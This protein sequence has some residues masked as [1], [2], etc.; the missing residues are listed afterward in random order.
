MT[1]TVQQME[2]LLQGQ[3]EFKQWAFSML[4]TRLKTSYAAAPT[5]ANLEKCVGEIN[6]FLEKYQ[7]IMAQDFA[8]IQAI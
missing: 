3:Y 5:P 7:P 2:K 6:T 8:I 1:V 4:L